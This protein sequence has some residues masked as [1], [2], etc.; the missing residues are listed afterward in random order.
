MEGVSEVLR[1]NHKVN[2]K[3]CEL[4]YKEVQYLGLIS[5]ESR[6]TQRI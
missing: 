4:F 6:G 2:T 5:L 1:A 3:K